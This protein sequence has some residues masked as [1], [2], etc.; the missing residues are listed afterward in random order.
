[1]LGRFVSLPLM[2]MAILATACAAG[3]VSVINSM[4]DEPSAAGIDGEPAFITPIDAAVAVN[5]AA[6]DGQPPVVAWVTHDDV[7]VAELDVETGGLVDE[8]T[9]VGDLVP[10]AHPIERPAVALYPDG[11][12]DVAFTS[13]QTGGASVYLSRDGAP[14]QAI[15]GAPQHETNL[16][17]MTID[18]NG[19]PILTWLEDATLSV[20]RSGDGGLEETESVD[21]L[22]CDCCNPVPALLDE[23]LVIA[24]RDFDLVDGDVVRNVAAVRSSDGGR[25]FDPSVQVADD[26]WLLAGCPFTGPDIVAVD[27]V[28]IIAWMD[29]RQSVYPDQSASSIWV[30]RSTDGGVSFGEDLVVAENGLHRWPAMAV[31]DSEVIHMFWETQ[32]QDGG[33]SYAWSDDVGV[34]FSEPVLLLDRD[35]IGGGAPH[36]PSAVFHDGHLVATWADAREGYV[37]AWPVT[38]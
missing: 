2:A 18:S 3:T 11:S 4:Q 34:S 33:L 37:A 1:M 27:R 9:V 21:D 13:L 36:S 23:S 17:H 15:S 32:G 25:T 12:V 22:T 31:D 5:V 26:D 29:A 6:R 7:I 14:P 35:M 16:V 24:Y 8:H 30:D 10:I 38:R 28:L 19:S 20:A